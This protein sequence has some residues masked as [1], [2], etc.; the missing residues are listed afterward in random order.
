M[1]KSQALGDEEIQLEMTP[2]IDVTFLLLIF[3]LLTLKF[4]VLE[5]KLAAYLPRDAGAAPAQGEPLERVEVRISV[6]RA[7]ERQHPIGSPFEGRPWSAS[8]AR[9]GMRFEWQGRVLEYAL[10]P[11][12]TQDLQ[13]LEGWL[14]AAIQSDP[15]LRSSIQATQDCLYGDVMGVLDGLLES[16]YERIGIGAALRAGGGGLLGQR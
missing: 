2:M 9:Q 1:T 12:Q 8:D 5:G 6:L 13:E 3:F 7:G 11:R 14:R 10:G 16:G 4:K 15:E